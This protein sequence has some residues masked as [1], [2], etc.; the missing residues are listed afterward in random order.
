MVANNKVLKKLLLTHA[1]QQWGKRVIE[2][3]EFLADVGV[4]ANIIIIFPIS[5]IITNS[6]INN[7]KITLYLPPLF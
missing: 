1:W 6:P 7:S 2:K 4:P 3:V 5:Y